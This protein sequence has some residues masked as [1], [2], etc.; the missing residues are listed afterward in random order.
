MTFVNNLTSN[1]INSHSSSE[2]TPLTSQPGKKRP[3][4]VGDNQYEALPALIASM[5]EGDYLSVPCMKKGD[6][7][8]VQ[9][10]KIYIKHESRWQAFRHRVSYGSGRILRPLCLVPFLYELGKN[11]GKRESKDS[12]E[13]KDSFKKEKEV[14]VALWRASTSMWHNP[15]RVS[16]SIRIA[17]AFK[18]AGDQELGLESSHLT[19]SR[20]PISFGASRFPL[21]ESAYKGQAMRIGRIGYQDVRNATLKSIKNRFGKQGR[22]LVKNDSLGDLVAPDYAR[23]VKLAK[24][25][26]I[27]NPEFKS[28]PK[29][30]DFVAGRIAQ[31]AKN[32]IQVANLIENIDSLG[33][34]NKI[35]QLTAKQ[36]R[37]QLRFSSRA[38]K[39]IQKLDGDKRNWRKQRLE[40]T[41]ASARK[42]LKLRQS[43]PLNALESKRD[44]GIQL[45]QKWRQEFS[46]PIPFPK[47]FGAK[48]EI[49][50]TA[51]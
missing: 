28:D 22:R 45:M 25:L 1:G 38:R 5:K 33:M 48:Y 40:G 3:Q 46:Q 10:R 34:N 20:S 29:W 14:E 8:S 43:I 26:L 35:T 16:K 31:Q 51:W 4:T 42:K 44:E 32:Y 17:L 37:E 47:P 7:P 19:D 41:I 11:L 27:K 23:R 49:K 6:S 2:T 36:K 18:T 50:D 15:K 13:S 21:A 30:L 39:A 24:L 9:K 12:L